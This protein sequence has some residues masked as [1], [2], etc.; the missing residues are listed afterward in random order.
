M[1]SVLLWWG[2]FASSVAM[3]VYNCA[4]V[5]LNKCEP[6]TDANSYWFS[7]VLSIYRHA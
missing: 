1:L 2:Q 5:A 4:R 3:F 7:F 6:P